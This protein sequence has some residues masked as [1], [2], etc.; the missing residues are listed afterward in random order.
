MKVSCNLIPLCK[1][2]CRPDAISWRWFPTLHSNGIKGAWESHAIH[3]PRPLVSTSLLNIFYAEF[4]M[5]KGTEMLRS[6]YM[7]PDVQANFSEH[8]SKSQFTG[9]SYMHHPHFRTSDVPTEPS[10]QIAN[11][12]KMKQRKRHMTII[13]P[14]PLHN[15]KYSNVFYHKLKS[16]Y[17]PAEIHS[18]CT[19][20]VNTLVHSLFPPGFRAHSSPSE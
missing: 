13:K 6:H 1:A 10:P 20:F 8:V 12:T 18:S 9:L 2:I 14:Q 3:L 15:L 17:S 5:A 16:P 4:S 11:W 7:D 19:P